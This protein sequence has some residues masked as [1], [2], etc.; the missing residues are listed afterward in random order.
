MRLHFEAMKLPTRV[1]APWT[2]SPPWS[3]VSA[4]VFIAIYGVPRLALA[5]EAAA[6]SQDLSLSEIVVTANRREQSVEAIPY[7]VSVVTAQ[8]L[9]TS[10]VTDIASLAT[11]VP[12]LSIFDFGARFAGATAPIIRG[13]NASA[14]PRGFRSF[15]QDPVGTYIGNSPVDGGYFQLDDLQRVEV[16]RGPQGT[17]YGAGALGGALR[18]I[19]NSPQLNV[20]SGSVEAGG[21][22]VAHSGGTGY[23]VDGLIN[24]PIGDTIA[25]R[26]SA[27][28][29][30]DPGFVNA[31]GLLKRT[32]NSLTG[33]PLLADP[34]DP[35]NSPG[36]YS[37]R[38]DWNWQK[39]FTGRAA[40]LWKPSGSFNAELAIV[41]ASVQGDGGPVVN[42]Q[43]PGGVSPVDPQV[44]LPAG[45]RFQEFTQIDQPFSRYTN[46]LSLD[47]SIDS[48]FATIS[49]TSSYY[50]TSGSTLTDSTYEFLGVDGGAFVPYYAGIPTNPRVVYDDLFTD[51]AHT[52]SEELR[53]VSNS[54]PANVFDYVAGLFFEKQ[55]RD[56]DWMIANPGSPERS[57]SQGCTAPAYYG[58]EFPNCLISAGPQDVD[59]QQDETQKFQDKSI[60]G[61]LTWHI[62]R[63]DQITAGARHFS[64]EFTDLQTYVDYVF[65][66]NVPVTPRSAPASKTTGK[67]DFSHEFAEH[68]YVYALWSQGFRRGGANSLP[69]SGPFKDSPLLATYAPDSTNNYE[70]GLKGRLES[71]FSYELAVFDIY[72]D[73]PQISATLPSSNLAVYNGNTA[74]SR[75]FEIESGGPLGLQGLSYKLGF[76][77]ADAKL[78]SDFSLAA[79]DGTGVIVPGEI[80]GKAG[81]QLP[82][83]PKVST[84]AAV[85]Y[86]HNLMPGYDLSLSFNGT[87]RSEMKMNLSSGLG[88]TNVSQSSSYL[89]MNLFGALKHNSWR[90]VAYVNNIFDKQEILVPPIQPNQVGG[91]TNDY[92]VNRPREVG[93]RAGYSF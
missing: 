86:D 73:K 34:A 52:F 3:S 69:L 55:T 10:G 57:V 30:Y 67:V 80:S 29:A 24:L 33:V 92:V 22:R 61:E 13:I 38:R 90:F 18:L 6:G 84:T 75:G 23:V 47:M 42:P 51:S 27:K 11:E 7:S 8:Q 79:N 31:Y 21:A 41:H 37:D 64:Q 39:T 76:S 19:P 40:A 48:G 59:F 45:G 16:L 28:Y 63:R 4:A 46:L 89:V 12:G 77:Y 93:V 44:T 15:E 56:G 5:Q 36:I 74:T 14:E 65:P 72:W 70:L 60:F 35:V 85:N 88:T 68:Q 2:F 20:F 71:G 62:T 82:G 91:L 26:A 25:F 32:N 53:L 49:S 66:I 54:S 58:A 78:S 81:E 1:K 17:L 50:T 9:E 87:Y 43:F 83:S